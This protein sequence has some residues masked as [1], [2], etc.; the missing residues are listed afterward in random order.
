MI[1]VFKKILSDAMVSAKESILNG[2]GANHTSGAD[3]REN[4]S[5]NT[6]KGRDTYTS[7]NTYNA[8]K[9]KKP[10][11]VLDG[12]DV[13]SFY[14][15]DFSEEFNMA[16]IAPMFAQENV[17]RSCVFVPA[18]QRYILAY[19]HLLNDYSGKKGEDLS[20]ELLEYVLQYHKDIVEP[21]GNVELSTYISETETING[22][23]CY[24]FIGDIVG[25]DNI[26]DEIWTKYQA[27]SFYTLIKDNK[28]YAFYSIEQYKASKHYFEEQNHNL[29]KMASTIRDK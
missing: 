10:E 27:F 22:I 29:D 21:K 2:N 24:H 15:K 17:G 6:Q 9:E 1:S 25:D 28:G 5:S 14:I 12:K 7:T 18:D 16:F 8:V 26:N 11:Y 20:P 23:E 19:T 3:Y 4:A 13:D